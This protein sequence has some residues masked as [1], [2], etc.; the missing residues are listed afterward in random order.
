MIR[1]S[2]EKAYISSL[3]SLWLIVPSRGTVFNSS[4]AN[5]V[6]RAGFIV[7][8]YFLFFGCAV[9][10]PAR[11]LSRN[12][13]R[14]QL[15]TIFTRVWVAPGLL[16]FTFIYLKFVNSGYLLILAPPVCAWMGLWASVWYAN[17]RLN[18]ALKMLTLTGCAAINTMIF[19]WAP[20]YCS[21]GDVLRFEKQLR[22]IIGEVPQI[23]PAGET[24]IVGFDSHFLG[25]RH[26]GYYL[27]G[28]L[29]VQ[30]PEVQLMPGKRIF[31]MEN[32]DTH[33]VNLLDISS[34]RNFIIFPLPSGDSE[35]SDYMATVR[36]RFP[37]GE[38]RTIVRNGSEF[39]IAPVA[40]LRFLFPGCIH[41]TESDRAR[42]VTHSEQRA[43]LTDAPSLSG[44]TNCVFP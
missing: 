37:P 39:A 20:V 24:M 36:K 34:I 18:R 2:G 42:T 6:A 38:L 13:C 22:N 30:F 23:A 44:R 25:Y 43:T 10:L 15:I 7:G 29:T 1:I 17:L 27:P 33:I 40:D 5:S 11:A 3:L 4:V 35:Y 8:I 21:Y 31:S 32:G 26:A 14:D 28:Y 12:T 41:R 9:F 19:I 16:F